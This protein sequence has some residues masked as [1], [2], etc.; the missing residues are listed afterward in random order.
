MLSK[1]AS[2]KAYHA[3]P[4]E[5][6]Y[7]LVVVWKS[8]IPSVQ[9]RKFRSGQLSSCQWW[10]SWQQREIE[11]RRRLSESRRQTGKISKFRTI[12]V[13]DGSACSSTRVFFISSMHGSVPPFQVYTLQLPYKMYIKKPSKLFVWLKRTLKAVVTNRRNTCSNRILD[14][15]KVWIVQSVKFSIL[16]FKLLCWGFLWESQSGKLPLS[17]SR[18]SQATFVSIKL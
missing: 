1:N 2:T 3:V 8:E 14:M 11:A 9:L 4:S 15:I 13:T 5:A 16:H 6:I 10:S 17:H 12:L 7:I 18:Q